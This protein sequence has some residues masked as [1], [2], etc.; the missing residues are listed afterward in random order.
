[1]RI[2]DLIKNIHNRKIILDFDGTITN[3]TTP[4]DEVRL[5]I[6]QML[7]INEVL[8]LGRMY[9]FSQMRKKNREYLKIIRKAENEGLNLSAVSELFIYLKTTKTS[10]SICSN[11]SRETI[12]RFLKH[13][14]CISR[15]NKIIGVEDVSFMKPSPEGLKKIVNKYPKDYI[16]IGDFIN[17]EIASYF[18]GV[19]FCYY[20]Y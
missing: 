1:M 8:D 19:E 11:N 15:V 7:G 13:N 5:K 20:D 4:W 12:I 10:F 2:D 16:F 6:S 9:L 18:A 17:D 3:L 14:N